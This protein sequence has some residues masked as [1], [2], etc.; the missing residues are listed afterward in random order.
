L[1]IKS[2]LWHV[3]LSGGSS[4]GH[5]GYNW[6][7]D[8]GNGL[9]KDEKSKPEKCT[10]ETYTSTTVGNVSDVRVTIPTTGGV[11]ISVGSSSGYS[12]TDAK[13]TTSKGQ[14]IT[15]WPNGQENCDEIA[16]K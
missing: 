4:T 3:I 10:I 8:W 9:T 5:G 14:K 6:P 12:Q 13:K 11:N 7:W 16:C 15:C 2:Y 1:K